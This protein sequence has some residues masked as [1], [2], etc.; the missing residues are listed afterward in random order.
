V[1]DPRPIR[2]RPVPAF[3]GTLPIHDAQG[4]ILEALKKHPVVIVCGE[5]GSGKTTQIPK[6]CLTLEP[7]A[8]GLIGCTQPRRLAARSV[9]ARLAQELGTQVGGAVGYK[10]R[11]HDRVSDRTCIKVMTDGILLA[12]IHQDRLLKAYDIL[13]VDEAHERSLNIDFLLGYLKRI[14]PRRPDLKVVITSATMETERLSRH[15]DNAPII[16]VSGRTY[17]VEIRWHPVT[18]DEEEEDERGTRAALLRAVD[19]LAREPSQGDILVFLP[20]ERD[21]RETAEALRKHHPPHT[22]I[23]PLYSRLSFAEQDRV[24]KPGGGRRIVLSTNVAET[25][26]TVPGIRYVVDTGLARVNRYSVRNKVTQLQ[27]EKISQASARQRAGRCGRVAAGICIRL[28]DENDFNERP[29]YT[30]PEILRTSLASVILRMEALGLGRVDAFPFLD[31]PSARSIEDGYQL[32]T[33]LGAVNSDRVLTVIGRELAKLPVDPR[34]GRML[35]AARQQACLTEMLIITSALSVADPRERPIE[36]RQAA[37]ENH[38]RFRD[39]KSEFIAF[40]NLWK[41]FEEALAHKKS[42]RKL[43]EFCREHFLS[44]ARLREWREI[45]GQL[46]ALVAEMGM[47]TNESPATYEQ[48]HRALLTGLLGHIGNRDPEAGNYLGPRGIRFWANPGSTLNKAKFQ[49]VVAAELSET[50]R[51]YART[52][53]KIEPEWLEPVAGHLLKRSYYDPHWD[54]KAAQVNA[55]EKVTLHGLTIVPRR[56]VRYGPIDP[57]ESRRLFIRHALVSGEYATQAPFL[58]HNRQLVA[59]VEALEHKARR[60]DVLVDEDTIAR[61]YEGILPNGV[62]SGERFEKWRREAERENPKLLFLERDYLMKH[63]AENVT[64]TLFPEWIELGGVEHPLSYRFDPGHPLDGV[65]VSLPLVIL[66]S[67]EAERLEWLVPG[68]IR[69]KITALLKKLPQRLRRE[70]V[71]LPAF[72]TTFLEKFTPESG[73]LTRSLSLFI[74]SRTGFSVQAEDWGVIPEHFLMNIRVIDSE[75]RELAVGRN[76]R[77]L[78]E[79]L[80]ERA[81]S[82]LQATQ[83]P[84]ITRTGITRWDFGELPASVQ[85]QGGTLNLPAFPALVDQGDSLSIELVDNEPEAERL[86]QAGVARLC[87]LELQA[88]A[89][90]LGKSIAGFDAMAMAYS[91]LKGDAHASLKPAEALRQE[92]LWRAVQEL[93][94]ATAGSIRQQAQFESLRVRVKDGLVAKVAEIA[95]QAGPIFRAYLDARSQLEAVKAP[96]LQP[97]ASTE[98]AH[99]DS[100][101]HRGFLQETSLEHLRHY[102]RYLKAIVMRLQKLSQDRAGDAEKSKEIEALQ[103]AWATQLN[104]SQPS[105]EMIEFRWMLEELRVSLFAQVLKTPYPVSV[106]RLEKRLQDISDKMSH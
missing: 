75:G 36:H 27:V 92:I 20:G 96:A 48:L 23:L 76:L 28:Y 49:W 44:V 54:A 67:L 102:P 72:V 29:A 7:G 84:G 53:A 4:H 10:V 32:L 1:T 83:E 86:S 17:P 94:P 60:Q 30:T 69:D 18:A 73:S 56:R 55:F 103:N 51:L 59:E 33:E 47:R 105:P 78:Q 68:L 6:L 40:I 24:F 11:F 37:D 80:G 91:L 100:L 22:E 66:G 15:F 93:M 42:N 3:D 104:T 62:W 50:T 95:T 77:A 70:L 25:S 89:K 58:R 65:T 98:R 41:F 88:L 99:L 82:A 13:I 21:I 19:E 8:Q 45:H 64:E 14:L 97:A 9:A 74:K 2:A 57:V 61:F 101:V 43:A 5:T 31:A 26:L 90:G 79:Q 85:L 38:A 12:E 34:I 87:L 81:R 35:L 52:L 39:E 63:R 106:K 46:H 71:P 16:E